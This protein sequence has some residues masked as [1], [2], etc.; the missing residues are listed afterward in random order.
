[1]LSENSQ[2]SGLTLVL[3]ETES[4]NR[5]KGFINDYEQITYQARNLGSKRF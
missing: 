1:M 5:L 4:A 2:I 3:G